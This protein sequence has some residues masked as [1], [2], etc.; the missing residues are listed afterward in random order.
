MRGEE[1][2]RQYLEQIVCT[3]ETS[4]NVSEAWISQSTTEWSPGDA[5]KKKLAALA[6]AFVV[7]AEKVRKSSD[8]S[9]LF[10][11]SVS[12]AALVPAVAEN[13][14]VLVSKCNLHV[15]VHYEVVRATTGGGFFF[16]WTYC[17]SRINYVLRR[18]GRQL[19]VS[20][21]I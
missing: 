3:K 6:S 12:L 5:G 13:I 14:L 17:V 11:Q 20:R 15:Q 1:D 7:W 2:S 21:P 8:V 4:W 19:K 16:C 9:F 10:S 18:V